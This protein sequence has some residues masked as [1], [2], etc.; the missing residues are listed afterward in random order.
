MRAV[1]R[2]VEVLQAL[3]RRSMSFSE[4][5]QALGL[6]KATVHRLLKAL[7]R[8]QLVVQQPESDRYMLGPGLFQLSSHLVADYRQLTQAAEPHMRALQDVTGETIVLTVVRG[9]E[10]VAIIELQSP[11]ELRFTLGG[12]PVGQLYAG[13]GGK[14]L[15]AWMRPNTRTAVLRKMHLQPLTE[16]TI[17]DP[18]ALLAELASI[19]ERGYATSFGERLAGAAC[20]SVPVWGPNEDVVAALSILAPDSRVDSHKLLSFLPDLQARATAISQELGASV[21]QVEQKGA[22]KDAS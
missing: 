19:R 13:A 7:A 21:E 1:D 4:L 11:Q 16:T 6:P 22:T 17:T 14:V 3:G 18:D 9:D 5:T 10:R 20:L 15:L 12:Q 2:A 8:H